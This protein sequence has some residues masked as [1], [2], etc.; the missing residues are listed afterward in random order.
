LIWGG[1]MINMSDLGFS[2]GVI[3]ETLVSTYGLGGQPN[4]APMGTIM[5]QTRFMVLRIY[6]SSLTYKN[7]QTKKCAVVNITSDPEMFY[8]TAFKE[9]NPG[10]RIPQELFE[11]AET[12]EAPRLRTADAHIEVT[13]VEIAHRD[14]E[15]AEVTCE[16]KFVR[17]ST[18][19]PKAYC[20]ASFATIEA[21]IYATRVKHFLMYGGKEKQEQAIQLLEKI[22]DCQEVAN[23]VAPSSR[24]SEIMADLTKRIEAWRVKGESLR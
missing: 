17:A 5:E 4:V 12:V 22:R 23:R 1:L 20:R 15:K 2:M 14:S 21:I 11:N 18:V 24:Y 3:V 7:L 9:A 13:V 6:T 16:V 10:G 19:L 8:R